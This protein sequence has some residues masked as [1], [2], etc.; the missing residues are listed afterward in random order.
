MS[1]VQKIAL[2]AICTAI[3]QHI[4]HVVINASYVNDDTEVSAY[5]NLMDPKATAERAYD[6]AKALIEQELVDVDN[7]KNAIL[8]NIH[9]S[10][11]KHIDQLVHRKVID[12]IRELLV[13]D[14]T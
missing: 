12:H 11:T 13:P 10:V 4:D 1:L 7:A 14:E 3:E 6:V 5:Q 8:A 2:Q 9:I